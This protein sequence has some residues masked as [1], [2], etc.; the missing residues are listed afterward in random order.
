MADG[1]S[2]QSGGYI[3]QSVPRRED[4]N[5]LLG[6]ATFVA[7]IQLPR[8]AHVAFARS[9]L[10]HAKI[11]S[12]DTDSA[13]GLN[14]VLFVATGKEVSAELPPIN[15]MQVV[16]PEG[17]RSRVDTDILIPDKPLIHADK[18]R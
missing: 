10:P 5:L 6:N 4:N 18:V 12:V 1:G 8:M 13:N 15:G 16:T 14:G 17:W 11:K 9:S 3:G 7:D 2:R